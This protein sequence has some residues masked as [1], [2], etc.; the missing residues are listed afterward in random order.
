MPP[1]KISYWSLPRRNQNGQRRASQRIN[2][3][4]SLLPFLLPGVPKL[5]LPGLVPGGL[6]LLLGLLDHLLCEDHLLVSALRLL[7]Q[8]CDELILRPCL[9]RLLLGLLLV[10]RRRVLTPVVLLN[11]PLRG[12]PALLLEP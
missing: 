10:L 2:V 1:T 4:N 5:P 8:L 12:L 7:F 6:L 9:Q 3:T 11:C